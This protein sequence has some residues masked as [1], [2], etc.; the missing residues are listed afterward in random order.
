MIVSVKDRTAKGVIPLT[1]LNVTLNGP[2]L[3]EHSNSMLIVYN[4]SKTR[5]TRNIFV[6]A[7]DGKVYTK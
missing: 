4:D 6:Y 3:D 2:G 1:R 7:E 5:K